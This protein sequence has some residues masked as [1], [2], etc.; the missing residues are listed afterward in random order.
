MIKNET[1]K[2]EKQQKDGFLL[3]NFEN[4]PYFD[5]FL[6]EYTPK[7]IKKVILNKNIMT[8]IYRIQAYVR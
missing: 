6:V 1:K 3:M 8:N 2:K 5:S 7:G 4:V